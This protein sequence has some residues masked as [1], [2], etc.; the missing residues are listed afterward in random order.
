MAYEW[1]E[2]HSQ[3]RKFNKRWGAGGAGVRK[4]FE[5]KLGTREYVRDK[6]N[7]FIN[8]KIVFYCWQVN[9]PLRNLKHKL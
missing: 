9:K 4:I 7:E 5:K 1:H 2:W 6:L 8:E 3:S